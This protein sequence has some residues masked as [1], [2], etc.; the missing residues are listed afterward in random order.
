MFRLHKRRAGLTSRREPHRAQCSQLGR[1]QISSLVLIA[2][3][4]APVLSSKGLSDWSVYRRA[5][6]AVGGKY[7]K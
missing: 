2:W 7:N 6:Y 3:G 5:V 4:C 1:M